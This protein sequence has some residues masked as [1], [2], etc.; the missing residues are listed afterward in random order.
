MIQLKKRSNE[1]REGIALIMVVGLLALMMV[2]AVAFAIYMR[3]GRVSAG[4][5][6]N[7]VVTRHLLPVALNQV[8]SNI[9]H[10]VGASAYPPWDVLCSA[11]MDAAPEVTNGVALDYVPRGVLG[12]NTISPKW[13]D[14]TPDTRVAFLVLNCSGLLDANYAGG[15]IR[16]GGTNAAEIQV[17]VAESGVDTNKLVAK[18]SFETIQELG[19]ELAASQ[20]FVTYSY[21]PQLPYSAGNAPVILA[22]DLT[23]ATK[24]NEIVTAL[25]A[26]GINRAD[27]PNV[28]LALLDYVDSN[29]VPQNLW[30]PCTESGP[31]FNEVQVTLQYS[32][33][34]AA[35][36]LYTMKGWVDVEASYPFVKTFGRNYT[37]DCSISFSAPIGF[38]LPSPASIAGVPVDS[39]VYATHYDY[40]SKIV[41][42]SLPAMDYVA[43]TNLAMQPIA[44]TGKVSL[45]MRNQA[46][47]VVDA[48]PT[49]SPASAP[50][51]F[52]FIIPVNLANVSVPFVVDKECIDP[53]YNWDTTTAAARWTNSPVNSL[54]RV[55][56]QTTDYFANP[57]NS[58]FVDSDQN[59]YVADAPLQSVAELSYLPR[60]RDVV[61]RAN[62]WRTVRLFPTA[63]AVVDTVLDHFS[64]GTN[65]VKGFVNPNTRSE[66]VMEALFTGM[67]VDEYPGGPVS[68]VDAPTLA[69]AWV[70]SGSSVISNYSG[71]IQKYTNA[72][73]L[74][75]GSVFKQESVIRNMLGLL[76]PR[77]NYFIAL[78]CVQTA[79]TVPGVASSGVGA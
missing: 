55:N 23:G 12:T 42:V 73:A 70:S 24:S 79:R 14:V 34:P 46:G 11:G 39:T 22:G 64:M 7:D 20:K 75:G 56:H 16:G 15:G 65:E 68:A 37:I 51:T 9:V 48:V 6:K 54:G 27:A 52:D 53:R 3:T 32:N 5:F 36:S 10:S 69:T 71:L 57:A 8:L 67:P 61:A 25:I 40:K 78:M 1:A 62:L 41:K 35:S 44:V 60:G 43:F 49:N 28:Y 30:S 2:L 17:S 76:H 29:D 66:K 58:P 77:Q 33:A 63:G 50:I 47:L 21:F 59:M 38:P 26:S 4:N 18:R 13:V 19:V 45:V 72:M 74:V 31:M